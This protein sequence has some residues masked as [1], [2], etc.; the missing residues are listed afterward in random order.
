MIAMAN[1]GEMHLMVDVSGE[2]VPIT[3]Y[4]EDTANRTA[5]LIQL[6]DSSIVLNNHIWMHTHDTNGSVYYEICSPFIY[7]VGIEPNTL[8]PFSGPQIDRVANVKTTGYIVLGDSTTKVGLLAPFDEEHTTHIFKIEPFH[9]INSNI[10]RFWYD[11]G[12]KDLYTN[13][14]VDE[15]KFNRS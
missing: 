7:R 1:N 8:L 5:T 6:I 12:N 15:Q 14:K 10:L 9:N 11:N 13:K 2:V 3:V 4:R